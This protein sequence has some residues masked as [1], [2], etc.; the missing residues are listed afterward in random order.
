MTHPSPQSVRGETSGIQRRTLKTRGWCGIVLAER[1]RV[2][3]D[4]HVFLAS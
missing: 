1:D 4:L 3:R 2:T